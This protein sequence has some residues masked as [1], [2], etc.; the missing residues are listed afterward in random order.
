MMKT[1][2]CEVCWGYVSPLNHHVLLGYRIIDWYGCLGNMN[3][4]NE[5]PSDVFNIPRGFE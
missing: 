2:F 1:P 3:V 4:S 5:M